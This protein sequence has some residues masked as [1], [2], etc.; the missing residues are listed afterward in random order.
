[1]S[2]FLDQNESIFW[3]L[4]QRSSEKITFFSATNRAVVLLFFI[5]RYFLWPLRLPV[6]P[7][8][9]DSLNKN[10]SNPTVPESA[11]SLALVLVWGSG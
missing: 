10:Y 9:L 4:L 5:Y 11:L 6:F 2:W 3:A 8:F 1:M 7:Q